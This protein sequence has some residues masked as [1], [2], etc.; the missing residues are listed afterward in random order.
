[1]RG[2]ADCSVALPEILELIVD[3]SNPLD[4]EFT[5]CSLRFLGKTEHQRSSGA[6]PCAKFLIGSQALR[7]AQRDCLN[8]TD[9]KF[10]RSHHS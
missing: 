8:Q 2:D 10:G 6:Q 4:S 9:S 5:A 3:K 1:M 7:K